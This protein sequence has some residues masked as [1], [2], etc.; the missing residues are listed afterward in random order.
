MDYKYIS[1]DNHLDLIWTP[2]NVWQDRVASRW[3]DAAPRVVETD[4]GTFWEWEHKLQLPAADGRDNAMCRQ[5]TFGKRGVETPEGSL[6]PSDPALLL[7]HM[8]LAHIY[9]CVIYGNTRKWAIADPEL[10]R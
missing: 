4:R 8:D 2:R 6:P 10:L 7:A 9:A 3:K 5:R 1:A